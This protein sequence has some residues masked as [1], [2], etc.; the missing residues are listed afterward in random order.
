M[1]Q[2]RISEKRILDMYNIAT[3]I[4]PDYIDRAL[5]MFGSILEF[6]ECELHVLVVTEGYENHRYPDNPNV[7][8]YEMQDI[9]NGPNGRINRLAFQKYRNVS[10]SSLPEII[11]K[12]DYLRWALKP[13]FTMFLLEQMGQ[14]IFC[15]NDLFFYN[16]PS[17][18]FD[19][20]LTNDMT[21]SPH[22][23]SISNGHADEMKYNFMHGLYNGGFYTAKRSSANILDW[24]AENCC[25]ECSADSPYYYVDQKYLD[26]LPLYFGDQVGILKHTGC[27]VAACNRT[28]LLR[29]VGEKDEIL[30]DGHEIIFIHYSPVTI[31]HIERGLD[32]LLSQHLIK[33][34][35]RLM[36]A[37]IQLMRQGMA[38]FVSGDALNKEVI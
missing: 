34:K 38:Q 9:V 11:S 22:W 3:I 2:Q 24:W 17:K 32:Y 6:V 31:D 37:R 30:V 26:L 16:D 8:Y 12:Y 18:I 20:C 4:T 14:V 15:D 29:S 27:N 23:R 25:V 28:H 36:E 7:K 33:Y 35:Q 19:T 5:T 1:L 10:I 21:I 13:G